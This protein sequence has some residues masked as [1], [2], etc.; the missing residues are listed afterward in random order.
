M[1]D[2]D[3]SFYCE[4]CEQTHSMGVK[5]FVEGG[6]SEKRSVGATYAGKQLPSEITD[7]I[8]GQFFCP[9]TNRMV[10]QRDLQQIFLLPIT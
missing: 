2:Y 6:P 9:K 5:I 8:K 10:N 1:T 7:I 3:L 4:Q